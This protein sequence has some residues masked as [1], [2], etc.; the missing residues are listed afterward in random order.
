MV[1]I[2]IYRRLLKEQE[3]KRTEAERVSKLKTD[4]LSRA[5]HELR[6]PL[7]AILGFTQ[8]LEMN[9][10][11][12]FSPET[13]QEYLHEISN[14]GQ[15]LL[16][17]VNEIL[18][19]S[20][21]ESGNASLDICP[22]HLCEVIQGTLPLVSAIVQQKNISM[23]L[24]VPE[25]HDM[26]VK[27]DPKRLQQVLLNLITNAIKFNRQ[28][29][30]ISISCERRDNMVRVNIQDNGIGISDDD[31]EKLFQPFQRLTSAGSVEGTGIGLV[32]SRDLVEIM[33]GNIGVDSVLGKGSTFWFE[34]PFI[35]IID[36]PREIERAIT[37]VG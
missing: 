4:F 30:T 13:E 8:L 26:V 16:F 36:M 33:E 6:T 25:Q 15:H 7:N 24:M 1:F 34:L 17:L 35:E 28:G 3:L 9:G 29:G 11:K 32:V 2:I 5:S 12:D 20:A 10:E 18:D 23:N 37:N 31:I 19:L 27:A 21:I 22:V 14:A